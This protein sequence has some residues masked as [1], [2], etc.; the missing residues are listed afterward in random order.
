MEKWNYKTVVVTGANSGIGF[1]ILK[2]LSTAGMRA[3]G[4][5]IR[6]DNLEV[7]SWTFI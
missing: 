6:V 4:F 2:K 5:D 3:V 1:A 7:R